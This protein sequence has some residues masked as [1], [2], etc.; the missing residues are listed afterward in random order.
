MNKHI[1]SENDIN[2]T[3]AEVLVTHKNGRFAKDGLNE[4][5]LNDWEHASQVE[6]C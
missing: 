5:Q 1:E 2:R 6:R 3:G 4:L